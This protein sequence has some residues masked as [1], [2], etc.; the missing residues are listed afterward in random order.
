MY[1]EDVFDYYAVFTEIV[2]GGLGG[3]A[4]D[5]TATEAQS[6]WLETWLRGTNLCCINDWP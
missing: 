6:C 5:A 3:S 4:A 1:V 2:G